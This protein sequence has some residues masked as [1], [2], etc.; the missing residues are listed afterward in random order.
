MRATKPEGI[1]RIYWPVIRI[2][3][4]S[5]IARNR[6]RA[7][8]RHNAES[9][10]VAST[11]ETIKLRLDQC[12]KFRLTHSTT[13]FNVALYILLAERDFAQIRIDMVSTLDAERL[14]YVARQSGLLLY[15]VMDDLCAMLGKPFREALVFLDVPEPERKRISSTIKELVRFREAHHKFLYNDIRNVISGH[16]S[17]DALEFLRSVESLNYMEVFRLA[18]E[19]FEKLHPLISALTVLIQQ[20]GKFQIMAK[21]MTAAGVFELLNQRP[22]NA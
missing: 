13:V 6:W 22:N 20:T 19:F 14:Q 9:P 2:V 8:R 10:L 5:I 12:R 15:E 4:A 7:L 3:S 1:P 17:Q 11:I 18:A 16:R 21:E